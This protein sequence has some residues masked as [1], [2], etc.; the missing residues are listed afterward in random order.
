LGAAKLIPA[1]VEGAFTL[2]ETFAV[3]TGMQVLETNYGNEQLQRYLTQIRKTY[4]VPR[5]KADVPLLRANNAYLGYRKGPFALY[6][7]SKYSGKER[8]NGALKQLLAKHGQGKVP[9]PT[10]LDLYSELK[11]N[12]PD[13]FHYLLHDL[14]EVNTF[15]DLKTDKATAKQTYNGNWEV[16]LKVQARKEVTDE[17]GNETH[18]PMNDWIE[19]GIFAEPE[20]GKQLDKVLYLQ[21]HR[22]RTGAQTITLTV[23]AKPT[24]AGIDPNNLLIDLK[25]H[26]NTRKTRFG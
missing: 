6:A 26:D 4:E 22:I 14:F 17:M 11:T 5:N 13:S 15:W 21:K 9:L 24:R 16:T 19:I 23:P 18:V 8:V 3:Y 12:T 1:R 25:Q 10:T 20:K 2:T 7:L